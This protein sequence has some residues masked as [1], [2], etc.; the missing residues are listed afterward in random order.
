MMAKRSNDEWQR[1]LHPAE[2]TTAIR[3][4]LFK[5]NTVPLGKATRNADQILNVLHDQG[6]ALRRLP[7]RGSP[8]RPLKA[9]IH[10]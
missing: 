1:L 5:S 3:N 6:F 4:A 8:M 2:H 10:G 9:R 7:R